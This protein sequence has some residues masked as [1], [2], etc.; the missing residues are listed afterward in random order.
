MM[1]KEDEVVPSQILIIFD[2][3]ENTIEMQ[4]DE[5]ISFPEAL[6][7]LE[8]AKVLLTTQWQQQLFADFEDGDEL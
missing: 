3:M 8:Y 1:E 6:G 7:L 5:A 4:M 2:H